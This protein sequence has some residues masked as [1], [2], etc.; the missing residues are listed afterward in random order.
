MPTA[1][2]T[3]A[4]PPEAPNRA[5]P[6]TFV[7]RADAWLAWMETW[8]PDFSTAAQASETN[9]SESYAHAVAAQ[10]AANSVGAALWVSGTTYSIGDVRRSPA[11]QFPYRRL[12]AGA[13]TTDPSEDPTNWTIAAA[14]YPAMVEVTGTSATASAWSH[15][16][17]TNAA[18]TTLTLPAAPNVGDI[19]WVTVGNGRVDNVLDRNALKIMG[20]NE[21][22]TLNDPNDTVQLRYVSPALGWRIV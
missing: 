14:F 19:V 22:M 10:A 2:P 21:N 7:T 11:N 13:G 8:A 5:S 15:Y 3:L 1:I 18:A 17:L 20:L 6:S 12:T 4:A 9:A 16:V